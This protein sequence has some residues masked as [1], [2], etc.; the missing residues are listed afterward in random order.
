MIFNDLKPEK[1]DILNI[2]GTG[3]AGADV[4]FVD[5]QG[6]LFKIEVKSI[7]GGFN[8][9][10]RELSYAAQNQ[11]SG[12]LIFIQVRSAIDAGNWLGKFRGSRKSLLQ[13]NEP[14]D[15][16]KVNLYRNTEV[17][18]LNELGEIIEKRQKI[19]MN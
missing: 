15:I 1:Y 3:G 10:N 9:F 2:A 11:A 8:S 14:S 13:S 7:G 18:I 19:F 17:I 4:V 12:N 6:K 16:A 5:K